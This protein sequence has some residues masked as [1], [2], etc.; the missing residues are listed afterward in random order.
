MCKIKFFKSHEL[1]LAEKLKTIN[2]VSQMLERARG[3]YQNSLDIIAVELGIEE[4]DS[5]NWKVSQDQKGIEKKSKEEKK[6]RETAN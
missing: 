3:D 1:L 6:I 5:N 4:S 2:Q